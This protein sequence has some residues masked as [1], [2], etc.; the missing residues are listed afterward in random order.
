[1]GKTEFDLLI[2]RSIL[3]DGLVNYSKTFELQFCRTFH[4]RV[5]IAHYRCEG[6]AEEGIS[7]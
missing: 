6:C 3:L 5:F 2:A 1:M 4:V 7:G